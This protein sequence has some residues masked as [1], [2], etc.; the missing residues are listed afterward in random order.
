VTSI[1]PL[2]SG[3]PTNTLILENNMEQEVE[4]SDAALDSGVY[5]IELTYT[6][7]AP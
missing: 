2:Y 3:T 4:Y 7:G 5:Q 6:I 1:S